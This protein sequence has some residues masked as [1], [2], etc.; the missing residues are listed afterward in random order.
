[1]EFSDTAVTP[2]DS[3]QEVNAL[4]ADPSGHFDKLSVQYPDADPDAAEPA[5]PQAAEGRSAEY[6]APGD[7]RAVPVADDRDELAAAVVPAMA[8]QQ[9]PDRTEAR[10]IVAPRPPLGQ[11]A[12]LATRQVID[13]APVPDALAAP[14][15]PSDNDP[16][17]PPPAPREE[18]PDERDDSPVLPDDGDEYELRMSVEPATEPVLTPADSGQ[19]NG[20]PPDNPGELTDR[21]EGLPPIGGRVSVAA[22]GELPCN[23]DTISSPL[24]ERR[25]EN[26]P[27]DEVLLVDHG[28]DHEFWDF[29]GQTATFT[30][31]A[32][33]ALGRAL[34]GQHGTRFGV[35]LI[36]D[37]ELPVAVKPFVD[38]VDGVLN[39]SELSGAVTEYA[40]AQLLNDMHDA[41]TDPRGLDVLGFC[42]FI[43]SS[44]VTT[45]EYVGVI[46]YNDLDVASLRS[47][48]FK[49]LEP[50]SLERASQTAESM[51]TI[52][53]YLHR[54]DLTMDDADSDNFAADSHGT[55]YCTDL[56]SL[57]RL[58]R[59]P[60]ISLE[61]RRHRIVDA[62]QSALGDIVGWEHFSS[63]DGEATQR[64]FFDAYERDAQYPGSELAADLWVTFED[65]YLSTAL[66][67]DTSGPMP[68]TV[69]GTAERV[70]S[71]ELPYNPV[72]FSSQALRERLSLMLRGEFLLLDD[73]GQ[74]PEGETVRF[75]EDVGSSPASPDELEW[76]S[77]VRY[78]QLTTGAGTNPVVVRSYIARDPEGMRNLAGE[79]A[80][81]RMLED[82]PF[83]SDGVR[84]LAIEGFICYPGSGPWANGPKT[85]L[86]VVL[87]EDPEL[88][89]YHQYLFEAQGVP[90][91]FERAASIAAKA[92][93]AIGQLHFQGIIQGQSANQ[94]SLALRGGQ[95]VCKDFRYASSLSDPFVSEDERHNLLLGDLVPFLQDIQ[96][97]ND[98]VTGYDEAALQGIFY[99]AYEGVVQAE[100][101][102]IEPDRLISKTEMM[103]YFYQ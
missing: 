41:P 90:P 12:S 77:D 22:A 64:A 32:D 100:G 31:D 36:G 49:S 69:T 33:Y 53:A 73:S 11:G 63:D 44:A 58:S 15:A 51:G 40:G 97:W 42:R 24:L 19:N 71:S 45:E 74:V 1:M 8:S 39:S 102:V 72:D 99:A 78:G 67:E 68:I 57:R 28:S 98:D 35:L 26:L 37:T 47:R 30:D 29:D 82:G 87:R 7:E 16:V 86:G 92:G 5:N 52:M 20:R 76:L 3:G 75:R 65:V 85:L 91:T 60:G 83:G 61:D 46:S 55:P 10:Q 4:S 96:A 23:A 70:T 101:S 13:P 38:V 94:D 17:V 18:S 50:L 25:L 95:T 14:I 59:P 66:E 80:A 43:S 62:L 103:E 84:G 54:H 93:E 88:V 48:L 27:V 56:E 79:Y 2:Y 6:L 9:M 89:T 81:I 34:N 21:P